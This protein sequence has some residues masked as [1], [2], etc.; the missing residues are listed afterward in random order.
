MIARW[1]AVGVLVLGLA[2]T[3]ERHAQTTAPP[4]TPA[5]QGKTPL[6]SQGKQET[7]V[8]TLEKGGEIVLEF[9]PADAPKHVENFIT[10][11]KKGFYDGTTFHRVE[12]GFVIQGGDPLSKTLKP[13]DPKI[14]TGGPGHK[15]K[16][17]FNKR[18]FVRG[19]LGMARSQDPDSAGS[20]FYIM[21]GDAPHLN[22]Q[23]TAFGRVVKGMDVVDTIRPG[24]RMKS[25]KIV[26]K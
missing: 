26:T 13:G 24:D 18:P 1:L 7:A 15:V 3:I 20:Q 22:G 5:T 16:A 14:G 4:K 6:P 12:P 19:I 10:L 9:F 25:V 2:A 11:A 21:L 17:E 23:Y 8:I